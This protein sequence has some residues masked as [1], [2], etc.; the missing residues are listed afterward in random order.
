MKTR[1][2]QCGKRHFMY[3]V[4]RKSVTIICKECKCRVGTASNYKPFLSEKEE[5]DKPHL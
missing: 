1:C 2:P 4:S 5:P 3:L